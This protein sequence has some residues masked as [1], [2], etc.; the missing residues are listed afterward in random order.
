MTTRGTPSRLLVG[1]HPFFVA[2][3]AWRSLEERYLR[4]RGYREVSSRGKGE[5]FV[6]LETLSL[7]SRQSCLYKS[8]LVQQSILDCLPS[9]GF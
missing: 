8:P 1:Y 4:N 3:E 2:V 7:L 9:H 6:G 5:G